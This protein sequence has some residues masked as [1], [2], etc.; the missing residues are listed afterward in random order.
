MAIQIESGFGYVILSLVVSIAVH[1]GYMA[2]QITTA[3]KRYNIPYPTLYASESAKD[4]Q[5]FNC[6]QRGHQ[7]SLEW[8][9]SHY[10]LTIASGLRFPKLA[11]LL[12]LIYIA[13]RV[14]YFR[15]Y[16]TGVPKKRLQGSFMYIGLVGQFLL[17]VIGAFSII[18]ST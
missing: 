15:G 7:N 18:R 16:S 6:V 8:I 11:A 13:G 5:K 17:A 9:A 3:R 10:I 2:S 12:S 4:G 1:H 14:Q